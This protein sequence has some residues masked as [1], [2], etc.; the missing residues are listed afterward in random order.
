MKAAADN[1]ASFIVMPPIVDMTTVG[2]R[3]R[4][5]S[6]L[7]QKSSNICS[8]KVAANILEQ[9]LVA[10]NTNFTSCV[11]IRATADIAPTS[12]LDVVDDNVFD[13]LGIS[14][15]LRLFS[16][17]ELLA[18]DHSQ[19]NEVAR[20]TEQIALECCPT[21]SEQTQTPSEPKRPHTGGCLLA[22]QSL[23]DAF[24]IANQGSENS[25]NICAKLEWLLTS[26]SFVSGLMYRF[27]LF[28]WSGDKA[29]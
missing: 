12:S 9:L 15:P 18:N 10:L 1:L 11:F 26:A 8:P 25:F 20:L 7:E 6:R 24:A 13:L 21:S 17:Y 4:A 28:E 2:F 23:K 3:E 29:R 22:L 27:Q 14:I 5:Q 19:R 16:T